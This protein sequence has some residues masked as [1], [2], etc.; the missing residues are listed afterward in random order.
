MEFVKG[1]TLESLIKRSGHLEPKQALEIT[2]QVAAGLAAI[3]EEKLVH[4]DI[5]PTNIMVTLGEGGTVTAKIID[6]RFEGETIS[7][8]STIYWY[9][10]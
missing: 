5:K 1:E 2:V 8:V 3:H 9:A 10:I 6:P 7:T 4:R